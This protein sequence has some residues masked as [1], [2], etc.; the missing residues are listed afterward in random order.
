MT[1][2]PILLVE[3]DPAQA[4]L[5]ELV[6]RAARLRNEVQVAPSGEQALA[7]LSGEGEFADRDAHPLPILVLCDLHLPRQSGLEVLSFIRQQRSLD[8]VPVVMLSSSTESADINRA[9]ELG[10]E[11]YLVKPVAFSA[12]LDTLTGLELPWILLAREA[13]KVDA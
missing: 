8:L 11:S 6:L 3:D 5:V 13:P 7:Y 10:A 1:A 9:V 2:A 4:R 12:L